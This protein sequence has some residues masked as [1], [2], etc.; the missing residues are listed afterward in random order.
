MDTA[1]RMTRERAAA[2]NAFTKP[3]STAPPPIFFFN[4]IWCGLF[5]LLETVVQNPC[6]RVYKPKSIRIWVLGVSAGT[7]LGTCGQPIFLLGAALVSTELEWHMN[8]WRSIRAL[9]EVS[10]IVNSYTCIIQT[11]YAP[12]SLIIGIYVFLLTCKHCKN[13]WIWKG[14]KKQR[15]RKYIYIYVHICIYT[16]MSEANEQTNQSINDVHTFN[17]YTTVVN[18]TITVWSSK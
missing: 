11:S 2:K 8:H 15:K 1:A 13:R 17:I 14:K 9:F 10:I 3:P 16:Y 4:M 12:I 18:I 7:E 6:L 5:L